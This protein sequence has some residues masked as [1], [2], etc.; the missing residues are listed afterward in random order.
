[1]RRD[2][3]RFTG[4]CRDVWQGADFSGYAARVN[5][6]SG[7]TVRPARE[8]LPVRAVTPNMLVAYNMA[9]WRQANGMT[10]PALGEELG[11]WTKGAVS[12]A[13][14]SWDGR[15][16]RKFDA[17]EIADMAAVFR[18]PV[19]ALFLPPPDD[20]ESVT[21]VIDGDDGPVPMDEYYSL[22]M[23]DLDWEADTPAAAAYQQAVITASAKYAGSD[24]AQ[25][26][27]DAAAAVAGEQVKGAL[28]DAQ[29]TR[30]AVLGLYRLAD[31]LL[32]ENQVLQDALER[33]LRQEGS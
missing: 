12:A 26:V 22:L 32:A 14:R 8:P 27:A 30:V 23:P 3:A 4:L 15:R 19:P 5:D 6:D 2:E 10:Q 9:R 20:G 1:M 13:E 28:E 31:R 25:Q 11:G 29:E 33:A 7:D 24:V 17:D 16:V 18:V 21:Y